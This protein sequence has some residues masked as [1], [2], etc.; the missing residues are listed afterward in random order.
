MPECASYRGGPIRP[1]LRLREAEAG[2]F[3]VTE[4]L[5]QPG[6][7]LPRHIHEQPCLTFVLRG[8][9]LE[10]Y[11]RTAA[12]LDPTTLL[13]KPGEVEHRDLMGAE[14]STILFVEPTPDRHRL[15]SSTTPALDVVSL[16]RNRCIEFQAL[17]LRRELHGA[18]PAGPL[19][20]EA[21]LL[22]V[23]ALAERETARFNG[24]PPAWLGRIREELDDGSAP[25]P[26]IT[27]LSIAAG[28]HPTGLI[29][30]FRR[31]YGVNPG[32]YV[33]S[34]RLE[35]ATRDLIDSD[36]PVAQIALDHGF[37]DQSHFG[38]VFKRSTGLSPAA[39]RRA[40]G[41]ASAP[42]D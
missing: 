34:R 11:G 2:G 37:A 17:R 40:H 33:R 29:R 16:L 19:M 38:R 21:I 6:V 35:R 4:A 3:L 41:S 1:A 23:L 20:I 14:G 26:S 24:P 36:K 30:A 25:P 5:F 32:E 8:N 18:E 22:E 39:F 7:I 27:E 13:I 42:G 12:E 28:V 10:E 31:H 15:L 9:F